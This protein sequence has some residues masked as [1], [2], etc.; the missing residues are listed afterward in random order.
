MTVCD[1]VQ[2]CEF[3]NLVNVQIRNTSTYDKEH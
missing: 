3:V 2:V 1:L